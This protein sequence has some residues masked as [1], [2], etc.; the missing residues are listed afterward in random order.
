M[1][2]AEG[3]STRA[4]T[5]LRVRTSSLFSASHKPPSTCAPTTDMDAVHSNEQCVHRFIDA[6]VKLV[7][8]PIRPGAA[9]R[10]R[11]LQEFGLWNQARASSA[12]LTRDAYKGW[13]NRSIIWSFV[14]TVRSD[15]VHH[16]RVPAA[17]ERAESDI[18]RLMHKGLPTSMSP[19][20]A[21]WTGLLPY[22]L[23]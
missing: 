11:L 6:R 8:R 16:S 10:Y 15:E 22:R 13:R 7:E 21:E 18:C 23:L 9:P 17:A 20:L 14:L 4:A 3:P 12:T 5:R 19:T 2:V 1:R